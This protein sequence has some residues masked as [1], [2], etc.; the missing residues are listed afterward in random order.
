MKHE[1]DNIQIEIV[2]FVRAYYPKAIIYAVPNGG[3][4]NARE[5]ARLKRQGVMAGVADLHLIYKGVIYFIEVKTDKGRQSDYQKEFQTLVEA[6]GFK[7][8]IARSV[9]DITKLI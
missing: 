4:R 8:V 2:N 6:Q 7:Y 1:E 5:A 3:K 9:N